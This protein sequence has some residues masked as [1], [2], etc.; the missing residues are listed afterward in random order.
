MKK[1]NIRWLFTAAASATLMSG[2]L[3]ETTITV[4]NTLS[5]QLVNDDGELYNFGETLSGNTL[6]YGNGLIGDNPSNQQQLGAWAYVVTEDFAADFNSGKLVKLEFESTYILNGGGAPSDISIELLQ[7]SSKNFAPNVAKDPV[8]G[9]TIGSIP[10]DSANNT[11]YSFDITEEI[12]AALGGSDLTAGQYIWIGLN[13]G[14]SA[15]SA[16]NNIFIGGNDPLTSTLTTVTNSAAATDIVL[17][18]D[19]TISGRLTDYGG[20]LYNFGD[21]LTSGSLNQDKGL[22]G[23]GNE[24]QQYLGSWAY[25]ITEDFATAYNAG[26]TVELD[27]QSTSI[28]DGGGTP[29]NITIQLLQVSSKNFAINVAQD[30]VAGGVIGT[31]PSNSVNGTDYKFDITDALSTAL[32]GG[33]ITTGQYIW[34]GLNGGRSAN[35]EANNMFIGGSSSLDS[36]LTAIS[37]IE[38][39]GFE[40]FAADYGL[41]GTPSDD[42]DLDGLCDYAEYV[43]GGHPKDSNDTGTAPSINGTSGEY[44]FSLIGDSSVVAH[45]LTNNDLVFGSWGTNATVSVTETNGLLNPYTN[46]I[47]TAGDSLFIRLEIE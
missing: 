15:D 14:F 35:N 7:V 23:D 37:T 12:S 6:N 43:F 10:G 1:I 27:F 38:L 40:G 4:D 11:A 39:E 42:A 25:L 28:N 30:P 17:D 47:S 16:A 32:N 18:V 36:T 2:A 8:A 31:I 24:N 9:G 22:V 34:I 13:G 45:I 41:S 19:G 3:A 46:E 29:S 5:G 20:D 21:T 26:S 33:D 44:V